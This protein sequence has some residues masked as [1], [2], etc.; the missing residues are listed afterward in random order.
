MS[1]KLR[2]SNTI[3]LRFLLPEAGLFLLRIGANE[4]FWWRTDET[5]V[6]GDI[7]VLHVW[8]AD[9]ARVQDA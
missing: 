4:P 3:A 7:T 8:E 2:I 1:K 6:D 9:N 5:H